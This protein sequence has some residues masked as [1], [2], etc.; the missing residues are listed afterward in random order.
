MEGLPVKAT[1][2]APHDTRREKK[3]GQQFQK[4]TTNHSKQ[5]YLLQTSYRKQASESQRVPQ[6]G[7]GRVTN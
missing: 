3:K 2:S 6:V 5:V 1:P 4:Q 7:A